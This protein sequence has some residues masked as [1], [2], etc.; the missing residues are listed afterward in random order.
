M[1]SWLQALARTR[2]RIRNAVSRILPGAHKIEAGTREEWEK[3]LIE[4]DLPPRMV[5]EWIAGLK[6]GAGNGSLSD[7]IERAV[8]TAMP[9]RAPFDWSF[10]AKP[11]VVLIVGVNGSG[12]TTTAAKLAAL[13]RRQGLNPLLAAADTFRAA[14]SQQLKIWADRLGVEVVTGLQGADAA[15]VAFDAIKAACARGSDVVI[16]DTAGRMHT[17][18][19]LME[20]LQKVRR[21]IDKALPGAPHETWIVLDATL[22]HNAVNQARVF[23]KMVSLSGAVIAKLDGSS[24]GGFVVAVENELGIP[25]RFCGLGEGADDLAP[26]DAAAFTRALVRGDDGQP[27]G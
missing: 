16:V 3:A 4:A 20:E 10:D 24:K 25:V 17:K 14:G 11:A 8:L 5:G 18:T 23:Q 21:S 1:S 13:A 22:G 9:P 19:N 15:A 27:A 12:K 7:Q 6:A 26:F 2:E